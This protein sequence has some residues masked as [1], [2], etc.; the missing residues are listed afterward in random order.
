MVTQKDYKEA[1][2]S[3]VFFKDQIKN[4]ILYHLDEMEKEIYISKTIYTKNQ[5]FLGTLDWFLNKRFIIKDLISKDPRFDWMVIQNEMDR[6]YK[7]D[8]YLTGY[9]IQFD[10][11]ESIQ[12]NRA[13]IK[14]NLTKNIKD[15]ENK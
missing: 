12:T 5:N 14:V 9:S 13:L 11:K 4:D 15:H 7:V 6:L 10:F 2:G 8:P 1:F 3:K